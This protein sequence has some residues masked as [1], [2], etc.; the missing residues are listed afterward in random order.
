[1][2]LGA[3]RCVGSGEGEEKDDEIEGSRE[4][5]EG[6]RGGCEGIKSPDYQAWELGKL[7]QKRR[8]GSQ[9][10][11]E[12]YTQRS[13]LVFPRCHRRRQRQRRRRRPNGLR[14]ALARAIFRC[15]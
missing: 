11:E 1:M 2:G 15:A 4:G 3:V 13:I 8:F 9:G 5:R 6:G 12:K 14:L 10:N 7:S